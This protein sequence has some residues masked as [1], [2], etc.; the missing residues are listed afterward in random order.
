MFKIDVLIFSLI[1]IGPGLAY[2]LINDFLYQERKGTPNVYEYLLE[3]AVNGLVIFFISW[4]VIRELSFFEILQIEKFDSISQM[5]F[6]FNQLKYAFSYLGLSL[7][8]SVI[9]WFAVDTYIFRFMM[10]AK[11]IIMKNRTGVNSDA[12]KSVYNGIFHNTEYTKRIMPVSI[13]KNGEIITSGIIEAWNPPNSDKFDFEIGSVEEVTEIIEQDKLKDE[14]D[15]ILDG[16]R[17]DYVI[18]ESDMVIRFYTRKKLEK[19]WNNKYRKS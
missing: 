7:I 4:F 10:K 19:Y 12:Y 8:I 2:K 15:K 1:I 14:S 17:I 11:N 16:I 3:P 13:M 18:P 6:N 9:W 5:I